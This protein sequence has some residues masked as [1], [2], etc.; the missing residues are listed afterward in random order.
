MRFA[1]GPAF[2]DVENVKKIVPF[3]ERSEAK[4]GEEIEIADCAFRGIDVNA[5]KVLWGVQ[6]LGVMSQTLLLNNNLPIR[7]KLLSYALEFVLKQDL[8]EK[9]CAFEKQAEYVRGRIT[10]ASALGQG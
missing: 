6:L 1:L 4:F 5:V 9:Q 10:D 7:I 3:L 8:D 2:T